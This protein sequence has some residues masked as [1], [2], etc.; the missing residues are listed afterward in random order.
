MNH[1]LILGGTGMLLKATKWLD[2]KAD[3]TVVYGRQIHK[4]PWLLQRSNQDDGF[5][6]SELDYK[7]IG[8]LKASIREAISANGPVDYVVAWIHG[9]EPN[10]LHTILAE[11]N[12][13][14]NEQ[15]RLFH[16]KG[17][18]SKD[19]K[20]IQNKMNIPENCLYRDVILGF[21]IEGQQ[22]RWLTHAEISAGVIEAIEFDAQTK[23][24]G[25]VTPWERKP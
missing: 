5:I 8:H 12:M 20:G 14:Q 15:Y 6:F 2:E 4:D 23:V 17:S 1:V 11:L 9:T 22:S 24:I 7:D 25:T 19:P 16:I 13:L 21:C 18:A 10:A 3:S